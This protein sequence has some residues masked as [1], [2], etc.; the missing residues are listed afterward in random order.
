[1]S[2]DFREVDRETLFFLPP[3]VQDWLPEDHLTRFVVEVVDSLDP[4]RLT[5]AY[6]HGGKRGCHP[7]MLLALSSYGYPTGVFSS[8]KLEQ[9]TWNSVAFRT[10]VA[11]SHLDH[12]TIAA[13]RK[14]F[15][16]ELQN[17]FAWPG[18]WAL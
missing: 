8:R 12:D 17:P 5:S 9:A 13:F 14:R 16:E 15:V 4:G 3:S 1:M 2:R 11:N 7:G 18:R 10:I 6:G